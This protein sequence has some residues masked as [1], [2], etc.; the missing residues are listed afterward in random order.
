MTSAWILTG[1]VVLLIALNALF[2]AVEFSYLTVDKGAVEREADAGDA[3]STR[4]MGHLRS[5]SS[6]LSGAQLGITVTSLIVG[7]IAEPSI[8]TLLGAAFGAFDYTGPAAT[9]IAFGAAFVIATFSQMVFGE[10]VP[11]NWGIAEPMRVAKLVVWPHTVFMTVFGWAV[12]L[13]NDGANRVVRMLGFEPTEELAQART[14][15]ELQ[16]VARRSG[17]EG[18]LDE[19]TAELLARSIEFGRLTAGEVMKPAHRWSS[20]T[21]RSPC[22]PSSTPRSARGT[23]GFR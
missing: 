17:Q 11:K 23:R 8:A 15:E 5:L 13:F 6:Q 21:P 4:V 2:V 14:A 18:T 19:A 1:C 12:K 16:S 10:L 9:G 20:C 7:F 22:R 3:R